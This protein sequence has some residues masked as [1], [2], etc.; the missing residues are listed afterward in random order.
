[1]KGFHVLQMHAC[2]YTIVHILEHLLLC[3]RSNIPECRMWS[4]CE[5]LTSQHWVKRQ[6]CGAK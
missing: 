3:S 1:M 6:Y 4:G 2:V 5:C